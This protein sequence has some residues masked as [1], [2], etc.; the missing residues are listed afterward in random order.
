MVGS[1][2]LVASDHSFDWVLSIDDGVQEVV[3]TIVLAEMAVVMTGNV[4]SLVTGKLAVVANTAG[5][6]L[7]ILPAALG[8]MSVTSEIVSNDILQAMSFTFELLIT[9]VCMCIGGFAATAIFKPTRV[10]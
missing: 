5:S 8:V 6:L 10:F 1:M 3:G 2:V 4:Y 7:L 9:G